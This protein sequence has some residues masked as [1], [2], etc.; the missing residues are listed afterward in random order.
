MERR[1]CPN[2]AMLVPLVAEDRAGA[3]PVRFYRCWS[4]MEL[5]AFVGDPGRLAVRFGRNGDGW[6]VFAAE[7]SDPDTRLAV[8]AL[9]R[10]RPQPQ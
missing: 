8:A 3:E 6:R 2:D 4:C 7:G 10:V 1:P 5:S 9:A